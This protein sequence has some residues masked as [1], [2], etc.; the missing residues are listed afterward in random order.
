VSS[1]SSLVETGRPGDRM[2]R[3]LRIVNL[4][5]IPRFL[6]CPDGWAHQPWSRCFV[7]TRGLASPP[8]RS[9]QSAVRSS[10][11]AVR[12]PQSAVPQDL[13]RGRRVA[14]VT[15]CSARASAST[16]VRHGSVAQ[17]HEQPEL[18]QRWPSEPI[19]RPAPGPTR[20]SVAIVSG[21]PSAPSSVQNR[22]DSSQLGTK[23]LRPD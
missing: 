1:T 19:S 22:P 13:R 6:W 3:P 20:C 7:R 5:L 23:Y 15:C 9:P 2:V 10:Q 21:P 16:A 4:S 11:F 18:Y 17:P 14:S 12:S 8:V